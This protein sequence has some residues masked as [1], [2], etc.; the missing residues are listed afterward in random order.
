MI[1]EYQTC[2]SHGFIGIF[3]D[4][5]DNGLNDWTQA[6]SDQGFS[7]RTGA[8]SFGTTDGIS[9]LV[10]VEIVEELEIREQT[11]RVI[12]VPYEVGD[13]PV[14]VADVITDYEVNI[15][16]GQYALIFQHWWIP[17]TEVEN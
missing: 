16:K 11:I 13:E 3:N 4:T 1:A 6:Q 7:W 17:E 5:P 2:I 12:Q 15:P 8:V 14:I 9:A 10:G